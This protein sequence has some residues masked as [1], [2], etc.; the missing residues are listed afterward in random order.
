ADCVL[1]AAVDAPDLRFV[2][3]MEDIKVPQ[4]V[5]FAVHRW[6]A[7]LFKDG[8][9][10]SEISQAAEAIARTDTACLIY[11]SGTGG[12]PKGVM[13][14]H[15]AILCNCEGARRLLEDLGLADEVFLSFL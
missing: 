9:A 3:T 1:P 15:G 7:L 14:S 10:L 2:I 12:T 13:L 8:D 4:S 11:T 5:D 6:Q